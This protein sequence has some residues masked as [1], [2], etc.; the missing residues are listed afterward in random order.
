[1]LPVD[2]KARVLAATAQERA[3]TRRQVVRRETLLLVGSLTAQ[4]VIFLAFGGLRLDGRA[5]TCA[6]GTA[7][8]GALIAATAAWI[9]LQRG[10]SMLGRPRMWLLAVI[11]LVPLALFGWKIW[12]SAQYAGAL[13][14]VQGRIGYRCFGLSLALAVVPL[15]AFLWARR[16]SDPTHPRA[17]GAAAGVAIGASSWTLVDC[18]CPVAHP[19]HLLIGH[20]LPLVLLALMGMLIGGWMVAVRGRR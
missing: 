15:A 7:V 16:S 19:A 14:V 2:L 8:G 13:E 3:A 4:L 1:M 9:S 11:V 12:W 20:V 10:R 17:L 18:W 5:S 6:L